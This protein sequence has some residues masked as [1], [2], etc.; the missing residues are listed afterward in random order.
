MEYFVNISQAAV[1]AHVSRKTI[2]EWI[3]R[4][5]LHRRTF[6]KGRPNMISVT[7]LDELKEI[8]KCPACDYVG[9]QKEFAL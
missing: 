1:L 2:Y 6:G 4:G 3:K 8:R 5:R 7:E 9:H